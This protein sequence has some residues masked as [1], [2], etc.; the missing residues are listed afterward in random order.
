MHCAEACMTSDINTNPMPPAI[1]HF[2][3]WTLREIIIINNLSFSDFDAL[4]L[5][6]V[7]GARVIAVDISEEK[8]EAAHNLGAEVTINSSESDFV[9]EIRR[10]TD[11]EGADLIVEAV[12][13]SQIPAILEQSIQALRLCGRLV[14]LGYQYGQLF[15]LDPQKIVYDELE[16]IGARASVRQD[17]VDVISLV[18]RGKIRPMISECF[19]LE[20]AN[21][22]FVKL[23]RSTSLGRMILT[24]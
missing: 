8:L 13:G 1:I 19:P 9:P 2:L 15:S 14:L 16:I 7:M 3:A 4:Q 10:L 17:L 5:A 11:G 18:E 20:Q 12:G 24:L 22:A 6:V 21:E 23:R